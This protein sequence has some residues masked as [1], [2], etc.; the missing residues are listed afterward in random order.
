MVN[1]GKYTIHG[2]YGYH[3][4]LPTFDL[5][6]VSGLHDL[7]ATFSKINLPNYAHNHRYEKKTHSHKTY[8]THE[9]THENPQPQP[10]AVLARGLP[11]RRRARLA[12]SCGVALKRFGAVELAT[13]PVESETP[14][15]WNPPFAYVKQCNVILLGR[16]NI[17]SLSS[18][19]STNGFIVGVV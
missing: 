14:F 19:F 11:L 15:G 16:G 6:E 4:N 5:S 7:P 3:K 1:L 18:I 2:S 8:K 13:I 10:P 9:K 12:P 17:S